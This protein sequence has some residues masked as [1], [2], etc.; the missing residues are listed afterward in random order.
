MMNF[1]VI[2]RNKG[3]KVLVEIHHDGKLIGCRSSHRA[4]RFALVVKPC[5]AAALARAKS[6]FAWNEKQATEY[7]L[8]LNHDGEDRK[9]AIR[10]YGRARIEGWLADG[11]YAKWVV[12]HR[13]MVSKAEKEIARLSAGPLPEFEQLYVSSFH[14]SRKNVPD[15]GQHQIFVAVVEI[16]E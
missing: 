9:N 10:Q 5:Q 4:Y 12:S 15:V 6:N 1:E 11:T 16:P 3:K 2:K 8:T 14:Q 13:E 7:Y